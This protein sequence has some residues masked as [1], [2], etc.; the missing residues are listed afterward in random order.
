MVFDF[1]VGE[2]GG[3]PLDAA[4]TKPFAFTVMLAKVKL[5]TF[6]F[7]VAKVNAPVFEMVASPLIGVAVATFDP[8][9]IYKSAL[10]RV[11]EAYGKAGMSAATRSL[12]YIA[13]LDPFGAAKTKFAD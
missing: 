3:V 12:G 8:L 5:P 9:P 7:T 1:V 2:I 6:E 11:L 13:P 10:A 4:V